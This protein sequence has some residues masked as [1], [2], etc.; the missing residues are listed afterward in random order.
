[1]NLR[2]IQIGKTKDAWLSEGIDEYLKRLAPFA[3]VEVIELPDVSIK[4]AG[5]AET[6]KDKEAVIILRRLEKDDYVILLD[7]QG[8]QKSSLEF[9][10]YLFSLSDRRVLVFV[11]GGVFGVSK[12]VKDRADCCLALSRL[13]FTHRMARLVLCEQLYRAMMIKANRSYHN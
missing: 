3:N 1:M 5:S 12:A 8:R 4:T 6:V 11:I 7:E 13:T 2:I 9:S 10:D